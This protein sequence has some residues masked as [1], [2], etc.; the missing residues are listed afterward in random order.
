VCPPGGISQSWKAS[1]VSWNNG[2]NDGFVRA[3]STEAMSFF[4]Q[5]DLP[6]T[7]ALASEFPVGERYF[8]ST[9]CQTYPNRRFLFTGTASGLTGTNAATFSTPAANGTIFDRLDRLGISWKTYYTTVPSMAIIPNTIPPSRQR[10]VVK[11]DRYYADAAS[12]HLPSVSFVEPNFDVESQENPQDIQFGERFLQRV[13]HAL[14][15]SPAWEHSALFIT[16]DE[17]GGFYDHVPPPRAIKP[18]STPPRLKPDDPPGAF[19]RYG[20]RVPLIAVSPYARAN[21]V[22]RVVQDHTSILRFIE[23]T[24]NIGAMTFR[25]ANAADMTDYF[26]FRRPAFRHPPHLAAAPP[27]SPGLAKCRAHGQNPPVLATPAGSAAA[28]ASLRAG[29]PRS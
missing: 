12:G 15:H 22:S 8:G 5:H 24:W 4:D 11:I 17:H 18:D 14:M 25:D 26:D 19:D 3:S 13:V 23:G 16:Y 29:L 6:F 10:R 28:V 7:Y 20:F 2:R 1:H 21:Y 9:L 27:I